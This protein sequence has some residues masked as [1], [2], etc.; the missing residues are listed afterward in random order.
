M[1]VRVTPI[2]QT[3]RLYSVTQSQ[4]PLAPC[5]LAMYPCGFVVITYS[6]RSYHSFLFSKCKAGSPALLPGGHDVFRGVRASNSP[7]YVHRDALHF[8]NGSPLS[9]NLKFC[10][11]PILEVLCCPPWML[12]TPTHLHTHT[13]TDTQGAIS[14]ERG[15]LLKRKKGEKNGERKEDAY[16]G[17]IVWSFRARGV[18]CGR[19]GVLLVAASGI[20]R[21]ARLGKRVFHR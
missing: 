12:Y 9:C 16:F 17:V 10:Q 15:R 14:H 1:P 13:H 21:T 18:S 3:V 8:G 6:V 2:W 4:Q 5:Q 20:S 11:L 7:H 19:G